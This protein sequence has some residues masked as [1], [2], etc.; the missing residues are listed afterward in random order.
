[1]TVH[2]NAEPGTGNLQVLRESTWMGDTWV[3]GGRE[4]VK[5]KVGQERGKEREKG[6]CV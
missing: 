4:A 1:M 2:S 3:E 6:V 5:E